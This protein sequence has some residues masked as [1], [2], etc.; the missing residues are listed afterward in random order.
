[1]LLLIL[2][3]ALWAGFHSLKRITPEWRSAM[4]KKGQGLIAIGILSGLISMIWGYRTAEFIVVWTPP[5][6]MVHINNFLMLLAVSLL[7]MSMTKGRMSGRMRHPMLTAVKTWAVAHLL[8]NGDLASMLLFGSMLGWAVW[9]VIKINRAESWERP[10]LT[11]GGR[12]WMYLVLLVGIFALM[13]GV[14][15]LLGVM[16]FG[17]RA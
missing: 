8:V 14:H 9:S 16:P 1:M 15:V 13:T 4:G 3:I 5:E 7:A 12:D 17:V 2:G 10:E 6:F 11:V